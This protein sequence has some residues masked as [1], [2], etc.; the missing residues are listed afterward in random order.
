MEYPEKFVRFDEFC[1][2]CEYFK[3]DEGDDPCHNCLQNP[4]N[5]HSRVPTEFKEAKNASTNKK[6]SSD[7]S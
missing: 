5:L 3:V 2:K 7:R 6:I 4:V 1:P